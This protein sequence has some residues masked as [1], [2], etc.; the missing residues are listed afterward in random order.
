MD[1][2]NLVTYCQ[3]IPFEILFLLGLD[4]NLI[5][6]ASVNRIELDFSLILCKC[7]FM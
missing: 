3:A 6:I 1:D 7:D 5:H 2:T 4:F